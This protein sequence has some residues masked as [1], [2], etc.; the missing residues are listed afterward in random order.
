MQ[1]M[2]L[3]FFILNSLTHLQESPKQTSLC[4]TKRPSIFCYILKDPILFGAFLRRSSSRFTVLPARD[5]H[6]LKEEKTFPP[7]SCKTMSPHDINLID[8]THCILILSLLPFT[9]DIRIVT[10]WM[11]VPKRLRANLIYLAKWLEIAL[12]EQLCCHM[13]SIFMENS[14]SC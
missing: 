1:R 5:K 11:Y 8:T 10:V 9:S 4:R 7:L 2:F 6:W 3:K 14:R 12:S 13:M